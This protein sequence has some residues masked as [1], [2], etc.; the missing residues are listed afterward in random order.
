[1]KN[2]KRMMP[3]VI[4]DL[5]QIEIAKIKRFMILGN[6]GL[7]K[8]IESVITNHILKRT[9][10]IFLDEKEESQLCQGD[11][12]FLGMGSP[13]S[14]RVCFQRY[15]NFVKFPRMIHSQAG[16]GLGNSIG[17]GSFIQAGVNMTT[18]INIGKGC[19]LNLNSTIGHD[20]TVGDFSV[21]NPGATISGNVKIGECT[22]I[23]ANAT[24]LENVHIGSNVRVGAG[25]VVTR[26]V[27]DNLT[28]VGVPARPV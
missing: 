15:E 16:I 8:E 22:L 26:D 11:I 3:N 12:T 21:I 27:L 25:A 23:G 1:M 9:R 5:N 6:A 17:V 20:V 24:V 10:I 4:V 18:Q 14:R 2:R 13:S 19:V 28:V 7:A